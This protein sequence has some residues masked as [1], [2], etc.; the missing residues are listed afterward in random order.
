[1]TSATAAAAAN[2]RNDLRQRAFDLAMAGHDDQAESL[3]RQALQLDLA[4]D[5]TQPYMTAEDYRDIAE[6]LADQ[7][8]HSVAAQYREKA[9]EYYEEACP[10]FDANVFEFK[11][12]LADDYALSGNTK[13][14]AAL[15][16]EILAHGKAGEPQYRCQHGLWLIR[17][18]WK[19]DTKGGRQYLPSEIDMSANATGR[20]GW[21][22]AMR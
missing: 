3:Y 9:I 21:V 13:R 4:S 2:P 22:F 16:D 7:G 19:G 12:E 20:W 18:E 17:G 11:E 15:Y 1:V 10:G 8:K 6:S 14:A 5:I